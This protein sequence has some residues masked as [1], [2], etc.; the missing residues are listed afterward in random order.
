LWWGILFGTG[1]LL[2]SYPWLAP[3]VWPRL[4]A[5]VPVLLVY[6]FGV[7]VA[8]VLAAACMRPPT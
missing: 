6:V 3:S 5:G 4:I 8:L 2:L 7:L 1:L